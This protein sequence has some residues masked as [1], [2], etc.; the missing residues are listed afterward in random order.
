MN[1]PAKIAS[2][3]CFYFFRMPLAAAA[4]YADIT[5]AT[6]YFIS[7]VFM[8][9][10]VFFFFRRAAIFRRRHFVFSFQP[11]TAAAAAGWRRAPISFQLLFRR[12]SSFSEFLLSLSADATC[13]RGQIEGWLFDISAL[14]P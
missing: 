10:P 11:A 3:G 9:P 6:D 1:S 2:F 7:F 13:F 14:P 4:D 8:K 5:Q 12:F